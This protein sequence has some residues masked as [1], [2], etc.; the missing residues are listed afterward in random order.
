MKIIY[1][2][3]NKASQCVPWGYIMMTIYEEFLYHFRRCKG[4]ESFSCVNFIL[5]RRLWTH[6]GSLG[7]WWYMPCFDVPL[8]SLKPEIDAL[9]IQK[10]HTIKIA[11]LWRPKYIKGAGGGGQ[12]AKVFKK[13]S[14]PCLNISFHTKKREFS[15]YIAYVFN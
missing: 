1:T 15:L 8:L 2:H 12:F 11:I 14:Q 10:H 3:N 5:K 7:D 13:K 6:F 4:G 9:Q